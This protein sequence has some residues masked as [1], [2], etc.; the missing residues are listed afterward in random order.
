MTNNIKKMNPV[1]LVSA[2]LAIA[3][4]LIVLLLLDKYFKQSSQTIVNCDIQHSSCLQN[5][6]GIFV[7]FDVQPKPVKPMKLVTFRVHVEGSILS[8]NA[9]IDLNM[10]GMK[11]GPNSIQLKKV[12]ANE[13]EGKGTIVKCSKGGRTWQA[14]VNLHKSETFHFIFD[15]IH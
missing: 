9:T 14:S 3:L 13:Y 2:V 4:I 6:N 12:S 15:V 5:K 11:M 1:I 10:P 7:T 8:D